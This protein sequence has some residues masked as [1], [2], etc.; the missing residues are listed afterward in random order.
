M[1]KITKDVILWMTNELH[2]VLTKVIMAKEN[3][4]RIYF[5]M[6]IMSDGYLGPPAVRSN[7]LLNTGRAG[8]K[9][10][11]LS[12]KHVIH[13][14]LVCMDAPPPVPLISTSLWRIDNK[15]GE[16]RCVYIL[17]PDKPIMLGVEMGEMSKFIWKS[18]RN[19]PLIYSTN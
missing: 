5:I 18:A 2:K 17:P 1:P 15:I 8:E 7:S 3:Y 14:R 6:V 13:N 10:M 19:A 4:P 16:A 9:T 12:G 11:D